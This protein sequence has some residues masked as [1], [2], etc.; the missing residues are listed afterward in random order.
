MTLEIQAGFETDRGVRMV[1]G[2][3]T[4]LSPIIFCITIMMV[5]NWFSN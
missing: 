1:N 2:N 3:I 4:L 5:V